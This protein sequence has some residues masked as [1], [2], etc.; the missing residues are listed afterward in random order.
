MS[1]RTRPQASVRPTEDQRARQ[2][3]DRIGGAVRLPIDVAR[4]VLPDR[5]LPIYLTVGALA[6][7]GV[8]DWPVAAAA[9]LGYAALRR[10]GGKRPRPNAAT[11]PRQRGG[12]PA[13]DRAHRNARIRSDGEVTTSRQTMTRP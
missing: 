3:A 12:E 10:W 9:G 4:R 5:E 7:V 13:E 2:R 11:G 6:V 8:I 1:E